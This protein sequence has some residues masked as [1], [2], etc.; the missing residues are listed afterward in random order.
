MPVGETN[1]TCTAGA[2]TLL[3]EFGVLSRLTG[4][5]R[6]EIFARD[7]LRKFWSMRSSIGLVG[8]EVNVQTQEV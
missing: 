7:V 4:D 8:N 3:L 1:L 6:F 2:G 5:A